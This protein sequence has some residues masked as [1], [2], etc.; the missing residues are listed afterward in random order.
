MESL[1]DLRQIDHLDALVEALPAD[2]RAIFDRIF[3]LQISTGRLAAPPSMHDWLMENFGNV[4][5]VGTQR[6]IK[7]TNRIAMEGALFNPLRGRRPIDMP[8]DEDVQAAIERTRGGPFCH[9]QEMTP[10]DIFA[11]GDAGRVRGRYCIT[12]SNVARCDGYHGLVIFDEHNPLLITHERVRDYIDTA[13]HWAQRAHHADAEARYFFLMWNC[14]WKGGASVV[15]G[16]M[17][18]MLGRGMHYARVEHWRRQALL[19]RLAHGENLFDDLYRIHEA[20][21]LGM[22]VG[23]TRVLASLTPI[24][25]KEIWLISPGRWIRSGDFQDAIAW[26]LDKYIHALGSQSFNMALFQRPID[27]P[28]ADAPAEDWDEFPAV[29]RIVDRGD[30]QV[31][32]ADVGCMELYG[33]SVI[34]SDPFRVMDLLRS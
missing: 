26:A 17:Q 5:Q 12:A 15:H 21:G 24:K 9:P 2:E 23:Q 18:V 27:N 29:V 22:R 20:L 13:M 28:P 7:V 14:L 25:E 6:V 3:H 16:H 30:L 4:E 8:P 32:T 34:F 33:S 1:E 10:E 31:R 19:Y 11:D